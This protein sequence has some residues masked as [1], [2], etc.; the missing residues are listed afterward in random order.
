MTNEKINALELSDASVI[1]GSN[2]VDNMEA[3]GKYVAECYDKNGNLKWKDEIQNLVTTVGKN[4]M[5]DTALAG[6]GYTVVGPYMG[7]ISSVGYGAGPDIADT[8]AS[9]AGWKEVSATTY[10]PTVAARL[11]TN[12]GW[13][14]AAT[15]AKALTST[16]AFS[17]IT[18]A[19]SVKG[20]F[21][22]TSTGAVA[23][24][25]DT[26]GILFSV[27]LFSGGDKAVSVSDTLQVSYSA[28][29]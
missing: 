17:I 16:L 7:L 26:N 1:R 4:W 11:T 21:L 12:G 20:A 27:G 14:S 2:M 18:N 9:H 6:S 13:N 10:F 22:V 3:H 15:G 19:G 23:T 24:L 8:M 5:L 29:L 25:G 28:S